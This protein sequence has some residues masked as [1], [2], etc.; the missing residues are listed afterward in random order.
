MRQS[1]QLVSLNGFNN[2]I[3]NFLDQYSYASSKPPGFSSIPEHR[4]C[5]VI[6]I[7]NS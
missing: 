7:I 3:F 5:C 1:M 6:R 4:N 2:I